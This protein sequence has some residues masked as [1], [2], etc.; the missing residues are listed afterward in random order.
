MNEKHFHPVTRLYEAVQNEWVQSIK[1]KAFISNVQK[2]V[3]SSNVGSWGGW[4]ELFKY[5]LIKESDEWCVFLPLLGDMN[6]WDTSVFIA[7]QPACWGHPRATA[8][9]TN[10][11]YLLKH[12]C[13]TRFLDL[14]WPFIHHCLNT[15]TQKFNMT[16]CK[17]TNKVLIDSERQNDLNLNSGGDNPHFNHL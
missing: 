15:H 8:Q 9:C 7:T 12:T 5:I 3:S 13:K 14:K 6:W 17:Q 11:Q 10:V 1:T 4:W 2:Q 16:N